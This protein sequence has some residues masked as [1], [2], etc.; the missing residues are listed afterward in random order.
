M[1]IKTT[2][3]SCS[4]LPGGSRRILA[5]DWRAPGRRAIP[6][7]T[8]RCFRKTA[9][10]LAIGGT[11]AFGP[12]AAQ[13]FEATVSGQVNRALMWADDGIV[14][15]THHVDNDNSG[16]RFRFTGTAADVMPGVKAGLLFEVEFQ[17]NASND[18]SQTNRTHQPRLG[19]AAF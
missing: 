15:E 4:L 11:F 7:S 18:V 17:S 16:T 5:A 14:S 2:F 10:I 12:L 6:G 1:K 19:R 9:L 3:Y 13:A 8:G